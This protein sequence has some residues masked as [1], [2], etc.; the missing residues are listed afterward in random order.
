MERCDIC[1]LAISPEQI[2]QLD[3]GEKVCFSCLPNIISKKQ[4]LEA[5]TPTL[6]A[7]KGPLPI[8]L[9]L[10]VP[11]IIGLVLVIVIGNLIKRNEPRR[12]IEAPVTPDHADDAATF[13]ERDNLLSVRP[14]ESE[15]GPKPDS[16]TIKCVI[17]R[18]GVSAT[19][20]GLR[21]KIVATVTNTSGY[22]FKG[23]VRVIALDVRGD[24]VDSDTIL[25][26]EGGIAP[27][28]IQKQAI[29]WFKNP[30]AIAAFRYVVNGSFERV[31]EVETTDVAFEQVGQIA[32]RSIFFIYTRHKD[33][34]TLQKIINLYKQRYGSGGFLKLLFFDDKARAGRSMPLNDAAM[35]CFFA[36][37][38]FNRS[39]NFERLDY[40]D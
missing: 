22:L 40:I 1:G 26:Q 31:P 8:W 12:H 2:R 16:D 34:R 33:Q 13:S 32:N 25:F 36:N 15:Y 27:D 6:S 17:E 29:L 28:G 10:G 18:Q 23:T 24:R 35:E 11:V 21:Q 20:T 38:T 4:I 30:Q 19:A 14:I 37:Y 9:K 39:A 5:T 3:S 7:R